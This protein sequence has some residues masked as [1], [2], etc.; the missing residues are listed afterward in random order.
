MWVEGTPPRSAATEEMRF[1]WRYQSS[2]LEG[3]GGQAQQFR[4][5]GL[6]Q[7]AFGCRPVGQ[8]E[9]VTVEQRAVGDER[10]EPL[11]R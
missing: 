2:E 7:A 9:Q 4:R 10:L 11:L 1:R 8:G 3:R 6:R 5:C